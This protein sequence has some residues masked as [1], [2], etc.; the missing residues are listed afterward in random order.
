MTHRQ[1]GL[2]SLLLAT[3]LVT[4]CAPGAAA[5]GGPNG[6]ATPGSTASIAVTLATAQPTTATPAATV[7]PTDVPATEA[8]ATESPA[9]ESPATA[10]PT[11]VRTAPPRTNPPTVAP[12]PVP[13][14]RPTLPPASG[15]PGGIPIATGG[16]GNGLMR[17]S[18]RV[19]DAATGLGIAGVCVYAGPPM[20]CPSPNLN[21][22]AT[23]YWAMDFPAGFPVTWNF[24]HPAYVSV[25]GTKSTSVQMHR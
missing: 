16:I 11:V 15:Y 19:T 20:G 12:T 14:P 23:G 1:A 8:P 9:T 13:T 25:L 4:A 3:L 22:D 5:V 24:Q 10:A 6:P 2:A 21:T 7:A 17:Y 18:G